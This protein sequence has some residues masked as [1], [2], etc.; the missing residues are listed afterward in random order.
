ML[1]GTRVYNSR[2]VINYD[3]Y[4]GFEDLV[5]SP[6]YTPIASVDSK[7]YNRPSGNDPDHWFHSMMDIKIGDAVPCVGCNGTNGQIKRTNNFL[8]DMCIADY[9][10]DEDF[11]CSCTGCGRRFYEGDEIFD[12]YDGELYCKKCYNDITKMEEEED[13][14]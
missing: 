14:A 3:D 2:D 8:C 10:A 12:E 7:L 9:D 11:F 5:A 13:Y 6:T 1:D 4:L